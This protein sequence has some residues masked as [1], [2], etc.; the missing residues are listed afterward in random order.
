MSRHRA[1]KRSSYTVVL[2][3]VGVVLACAAFVYGQ[4][5]HSATEKQ[6]NAAEQLAAEQAETPVPVVTASPSVNPVT[7]TPSE[8]PVTE[9]SAAE[10]SAAPMQVPPRAEPVPVPAANTEPVLPITKFHWPAAGLS[11]EVVPAKWQKGQVVDPPLDAN[12]FDPVAHFLD[13]SGQSRGGGDAVRPAMLAAHTCTSQDKRVCNEV[14]FPFIKLSYEGWALEQPASVV[15]ATG[16]TVDYT[17]VSRKVVD[18]AKDF[19]FAN[20]G[21]R[22]V[23]FTCNLKDP[24]GK[25]TLVEFRRNGCGT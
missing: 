9:V 18:K 20:D 25:I 4:N 2:I 11:V 6:V 23:V 5:R 10:A 13:G 19:S 1:G 3:I 17:L 16:R 24:E 8:A 7:E 12:G 15:D 14:T 22:L 21:C